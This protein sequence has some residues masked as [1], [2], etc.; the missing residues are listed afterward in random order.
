MIPCGVARQGAVYFP[1][2]NVTFNGGIATGGAS[3]CTQLIGYT[4]TFNGNSIQQQLRGR[5]RARNRQQSRSARRV[6]ARRP[7]YAI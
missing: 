7:L 5:W 4:I 6:K 2:Q 1:S 3:V